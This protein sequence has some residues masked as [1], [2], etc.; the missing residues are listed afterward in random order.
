MK[1]VH[2]SASP[3]TASP[4]EAGGKA[5]SKAFNAA[6]FNPYGKMAANQLAFSAPLGF[7]GFP[8]LYSQRLMATMPHP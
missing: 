4:S 3:A 7:P 8:A 5:A 1:A 6:R 2:T